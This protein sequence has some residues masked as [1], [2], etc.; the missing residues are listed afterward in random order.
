MPTIEVDDQVFGN[1]E[2]AHKLTGLSHSQ[3]VRQWMQQRITSPDPKASSASQRSSP[4]LTPQ[5]QSSPRDKALSDYVKSP[6]FLANRS[7]VDQFLNILSFLEKQDPGKFSLLQSLGGRKRRYI[8]GSE[9]ELE[10]SGTSVNPKRIPNTSSW[11]VTNNST[12]NKKILLRQALTLLGYGAEAIRSV[13]E[14]LR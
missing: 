14:S 6:Q 13:P 5:S 4:P 1:L 10:N 11:V 9:Q 3:I 7:V 12:N 2:L 8:A